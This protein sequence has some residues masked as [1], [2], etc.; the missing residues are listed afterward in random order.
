MTTLRF[1]KILPLA[2]VAAFV[3]FPARA[4]FSSPPG[5]NPWTGPRSLT[6][7]YCVLYD[8]GD[9]PVD[10]ILEMVDQPTAIAIGNDGYLYTTSPHGGKYGKGTVFRFSP[11]ADQPP[12]VLHDFTGAAG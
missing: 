2:L 9:R 10:P 11:T 1:G 7:R 12:L 6:G 4:V 8:L 5:A 3:L